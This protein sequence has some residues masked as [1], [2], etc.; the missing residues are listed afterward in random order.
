MPEYEYF[1][2]VRTE[3]LRG[4]SFKNTEE[5]RE[6][7]EAFVKRAGGPDLHNSLVILSWSVFY[8]LHHICL[9]CYARANR[10]GIGGSNLIC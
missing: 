5:L 10:A 3:A 1:R 7:I 2:Y 8:L 4:A 9:L 6:A